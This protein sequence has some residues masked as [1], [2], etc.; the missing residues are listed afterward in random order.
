MA[1]GTASCPAAPSNRRY[2]P[3]GHF[4]GRDYAPWQTLILRAGEDIELV[5]PAANHVSAP[6]SAISE[7]FHQQPVSAG[8][9]ANNLPGV[10]STVILSAQAVGVVN[11]SWHTAADPAQLNFFGLTSAPG[12]SFTIAPEPSTSVLLGVGLLG[13]AGWRR[14]RA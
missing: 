11:A 2:P 8:E 10:L 12:T 9:T 6:D 14:A 4:G 5:D 3:P 7:A 13:V 1:Q